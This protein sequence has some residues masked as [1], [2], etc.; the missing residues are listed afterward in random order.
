M[1]Q[2]TYSFNKDAAFEGMLADAGYTY[3]EGRGAIGTVRFG[4]GLVSGNHRTGTAK[5]PKRNTATLTGSGPLVASNSVALTVNGVALT[6]TV[7]ASSH[8]AT[9]AVIAGKIDAALLT[10]GIIS[11]TT[12]SGN[13]LITVAE[14]ASVLFTGALVTLGS[15]QI[16]Y[17]DTY[18]T[19]DFFRGVSVHE[20]KMPLSDGSLGWADQ[21]SVPVLRKGRIWVKVTA[22]VNEGDT[23]YCVLAD[24]GEEGYF[25]NV[26]TGNIVTGGKFITAAADNALALL[27]I[28]LP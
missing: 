6:A 25:T 21:D 5:M 16:T 8:A 19:A 12:V 20:H 2:T 11:V 18:T 9:M 14:D 4:R 23:A 28:N 24:S 26:S 27:E 10:L 7:Y 3:K 22:Q 17:T 1:S 15:G 13:N